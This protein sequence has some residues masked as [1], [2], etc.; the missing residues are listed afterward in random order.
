MEH[1]NLIMVLRFS[2][3][4]CKTFNFKYLRLENDLLIPEILNKVLK[5]KKHTIFEIVASPSHG[6]LFTASFTDNKDGTSQ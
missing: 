3:L 1:L 5:L 4:Y 6:N 2:R